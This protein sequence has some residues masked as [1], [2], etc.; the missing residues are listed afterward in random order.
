M[1]DRAVYLSR[2]LLGRLADVESAADSLPNDADVANLRRE[3]IAKILAV[4]AGITDGITIGLVAAAVPFM[5]SKR[6]PSRRDIE[7]FAAFLR[8]RLTLS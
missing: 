5:T 4:E 3:A 7:S 2:R 1:T 6:P 8:E